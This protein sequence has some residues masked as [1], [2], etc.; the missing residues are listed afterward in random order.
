MRTAAP[1][2]GPYR[3]SDRP[4][5][6]EPVSQYLVGISFDQELSATE[7]SVVL[8]RLQQQGRLRLRDLVVISC[9]D[10]G[11]TRVRETADPSVPTTA[12][13][14]ALWG[15]LIGL[16]FGGPIGWVAGSAVG[17]ASG[18]LT[19]KLVDI[20][21]P[22]E[23]V[24]WFRDTID[25]GATTLVALVERLDD[26]A[27]ATELRRFPEAR[28]VHTTLPANVEARLVREAHA[29][30]VERPLPSPEQQ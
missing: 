30:R 10:E 21:V 18:A 2:D 12:L 13:S 15:S 7:F 5:G 8:Q 19:A 4:D 27:L 24:A 29:T 26:A 9:D 3:P 1:D 20:G 16:L 23:W 22:D 14:G 11:R 28:V 25:R 17:A 6:A